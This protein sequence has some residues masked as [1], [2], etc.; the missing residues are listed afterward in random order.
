VARSREYVA[1]AFQVNPKKK[2]KKPQLTPDEILEIMTEMGKALAVKKNE[3]IFSIMDE[4]EPVNT[5]S[6]SEKPTGTLT[7]DDLVKTMKEWEAKFPP[8]E[9]KIV[10]PDKTK[11]I[12]QFGK[13]YIISNPA[14]PSIWNQEFSFKTYGMKL[15][16]NYEPWTPCSRCGVDCPG[17]DHE[18]PEYCIAALKSVRD[19]MEKERQTANK[20]PVPE[21]PSDA[22]FSPKGRKIRLPE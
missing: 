9:P 16:V 20:P 22:A 18:K 4:L 17:G 12:D 3:L 10:P 8:E 5:V 11:Y 1:G 6:A 13:T 15:N 21:E 2:K 7:H 14:G 19:S